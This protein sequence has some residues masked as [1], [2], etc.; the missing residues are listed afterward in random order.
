MIK[1]LFKL[2]S[3]VYYI[4]V[5]IFFIIKTIFISLGHNLDRTRDN[6]S[7]DINGDDVNHRLLNDELSN[8]DDGILKN[9][10]AQIDNA[11]KNIFFWDE[12]AGVIKHPDPAEREAE[13][14]AHRK[15]DPLKAKGDKY[16]LFIG[17]QFEKNSDL[18]IYNG[19][20]K[21]YQDY[22]IDL[23][24]ISANTKCVNLIQCK[25]WENKSLTLDALENIYSDL[26]AFNIGHYVGMECDEINFY[27][28]QPK[29]NKTI[30]TLL[31]DSK[32]YQLR[33]TLYLSSDK[34][35]DLEI[36]PYLKLIKLNIFKYKDMKIVVKN[37]NL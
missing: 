2:F 19:F 7:K 21:G 30:L 11:L 8:K 6:E 1:I 35:V 10:Y 3:W 31:H 13:N 29:D 27:L 36:G 15:T 26:D 32:N 25:N 24:V 37:I 14:E 18:V 20:I 9:E 28:D 16:E 17:K 5:A 23:I 22:G 4:P 12:D 34:I 33:K